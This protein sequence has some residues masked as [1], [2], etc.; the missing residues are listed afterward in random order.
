VCS[1][2]PKDIPRNSKILNVSTQFSCLN[3]WNLKKIQQ[4]LKRDF[5]IAR[6]KSLINLPKRTDTTIQVTLTPQERHLYSSV[7]E[8]KGLHI[9][10]KITRLR[11]GRSDWINTELSR[12]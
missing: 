9:L 3:K 7:K 5:H 11:Q 6:N 12:I 8:W 1:N 10:A 2:R 4:I